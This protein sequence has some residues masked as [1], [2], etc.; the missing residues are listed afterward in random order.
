MSNLSV[1]GFKGSMEIGRKKI[2]KDGTVVDLWG[3]YGKRFTNGHKC[4]TS[5]QVKAVNEL[6]AH[7]DNYRET[8]RREKDIFMRARDPMVGDETPRDAHGQP[9]M[10]ASKLKA[11]VVAN[12]AELLFPKGRGPG[13][14]AQPM[15]LP[16]GQIGT[17]VE[18]Y[19]IL[20]NKDNPDYG[21]AGATPSGDPN[22]FAEEM[23]A[24]KATAKSD[25]DDYIHAVMRVKAERQQALLNRQI[26]RMTLEIK[27]KEK[28][29]ATL[30]DTWSATE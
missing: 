27:S 10:N 21:D 4:F 22:R 13:R 18:K 12:N 24:R 19:N 1:S 29:C 11:N 28:E 26:A 2:R 30:R 25:S 23:Q 6:Q 7:E 8:F 16:P 15:K 17:S 5:S 9:I 14:S 3:E 20:G